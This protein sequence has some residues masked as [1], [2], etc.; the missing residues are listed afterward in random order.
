MVKEQFEIPVWKNSRFSF[1]KKHSFLEK[2]VSVKEAITFPST[3]I[4]FFLKKRSYMEDK[5][6][7]NFWLSK[8]SGIFE[9][10]KLF[11]KANKKKMLWLSFYV[12]FWGKKKEEKLN[13]SFLG[14]N[15]QMKFWL[16]FNINSRFPKI[17]KVCTSTC[18]TPAMV[19]SCSLNW[20]MLSML[21]LAGVVAFLTLQ[22]C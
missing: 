7:K 20:S 18:L 21:R 9:F 10:Q 5:S 13:I 12:K 14:F 3:S 19:V 8:F 4:V 17:S 15:P 6:R 2:M 1:S 16:S 11:L 22:P